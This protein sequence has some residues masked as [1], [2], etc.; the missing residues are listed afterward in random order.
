MAHA[1]REITEIAVCHGAKPVSRASVLTYLYSGV[2]VFITVK[3]AAVNSG[4]PAGISGWQRRGGGV[5]LKEAMIAEA[6]GQRQ[7]PSVWGF[8]VCRRL[9][10]AVRPI[11]KP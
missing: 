9:P 7:P 6:Y 11:L 5:R 4:S 2:S 10:R 8:I 1:F 3:T